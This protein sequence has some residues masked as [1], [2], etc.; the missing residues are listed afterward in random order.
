MDLTQIYQCLGDETR[1]RILHLLSRGPLCVCHFQDV[2][3][4]PQVKI[5]KHL[6]YLKRQGVV[7]STRHQNWMVYRLPAKAPAALR[8]QLDCLIACVRQHPVFQ[9]DVRRLRQIAPQAK[10]ITSECCSD[11]N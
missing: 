6:A 8:K 1:Q 11:C 4:A 9:A 3:A 2:L 7:E 5:S 10:A